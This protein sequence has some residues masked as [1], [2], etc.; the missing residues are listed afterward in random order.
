MQTERLF[1]I[2]YTLMR[3]K[4]VTAGILAEELGVSVRTIYRDLDTLSAAGIPVY[5]AQGRRG[6][7]RLLEGFV[8]DKSLLTEAEQK[9][10]LAALHGM[11]ELEAEDSAGMLNKLISVFN[12]KTPDWIDVDF[13]DW[14]DTGREKFNIIKNAILKKRVIVFDYYSMKGEKTQREAQPLQLWFKDKTWFLKAYCL[15]KKDYRIFKLTRIKNLSVTDTRFER[16]L[17]EKESEIKQD[18]NIKP[19]TLE[20]LFSPEIA[21]RLYDEF[22]QDDI[23]T[24]EDR[25]LAVSVTYPEGEWVYGYI[26]SFGDSVEVLR[27]EYIRK[28][29]M[30]RLKKN[31]KKYEQI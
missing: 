24:N 15:L 17:P 18:I 20:L 3:R 22:D 7:I 9:E 6:G 16:E 14:G 8:L 12:Q 1:E 2:I 23:K 10:M 4:S 29:V 19:V 26:L 11:K 21:Y 28:G 30:E 31:L 13:S 5:T 27:P 25:R